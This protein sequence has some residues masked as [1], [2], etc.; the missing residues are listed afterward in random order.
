MHSHHGCPSFPGEHDMK[1]LDDIPFSFYG[2]AFSIFIGKDYKFWIPLRS[3]C[4]AIGINPDSQAR[5]IKRDPAMYDALQIAEGIKTAY[6]DSTREQ[7]ILCMDIKWLPYWLGT[8]DVLRVREEFQPAIVLYKRE[9]ADAAWATFRSD[10]ITPEVLAEMDTY[11][12][13]ERRQYHDLMDQARAIQKRLAEVT[14]KQTSFD[15]R[16][17]HVE[18]LFKGVSF[19]NEAQATILSQW[20]ITIADQK[21]KSHME[22]SRGT[23]VSRVWHTFYQEMGVPSYKM[24]PANKFEDAHHYLA[25]MW[26]ISFPGVPVPEILQFRNQATMF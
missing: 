23:S 16:L 14:D 5:R 7:D 26:T 15:E 17:G 19:I 24:L 4:D 8:I 20:V 13:P 6:Q 10:L 2:E 11:M 12:P 25:N 9:F 21:V 18:E 3:I 22:E 1:I